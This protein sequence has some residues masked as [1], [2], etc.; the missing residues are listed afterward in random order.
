VRWYGPLRRHFSP[1]ISCLSRLTDDIKNSLMWLFD[2][3]FRRSDSGILVQFNQLNNTHPNPLRCTRFANQLHSLAALNRQKFRH[4][5]E[6]SFS[7]CLLQQFIGLQSC[8]LVENEFSRTG[9]RDELT[10]HTRPVQFFDFIL[11]IKYTHFQYKEGIRNLFATL[12]HLPLS[13]C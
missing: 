6:I 2:T 13:Q 5:Y 3:R 10:V 12:S 9:V 8:A 4:K 1:A 11:N 7:D